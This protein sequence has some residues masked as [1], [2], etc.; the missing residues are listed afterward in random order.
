[1]DTHTRCWRHYKVRPATGSGEREATDERYCCFDRLHDGYGYTQAWVNKLV[2]D[3]SN[4]ATYENVVGMA[5][6]QR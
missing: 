4:A 1:M 3:L 2:G 6:D 5:P